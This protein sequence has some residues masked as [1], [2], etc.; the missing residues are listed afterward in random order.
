MIPSMIGMLQFPT[1]EYEWKATAKG[2]EEMWNFPNC[3]GAVDGKHTHI[4][5][6]ADSDSEFWNYKRF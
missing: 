1:T 5:P 2:F 6:S 3:P 4:T